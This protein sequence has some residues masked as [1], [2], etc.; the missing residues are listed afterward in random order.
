MIA[1]VSL[2]GKEDAPGT[3]G[4]LK[5]SEKRAKLAVFQ[6]IGAKPFA[7]SVRSFC[8]HSP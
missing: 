3:P 8:C 1:D 7:P 5:V 2:E 4:L 6:L